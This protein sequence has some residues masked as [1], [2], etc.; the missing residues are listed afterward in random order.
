MKPNSHLSPEINGNLEASGP[1]NGLWVTRPVGEIVKDEPFLAVG[2]VL[3]ITTQNT[4]YTLEKTGDAEFLISGNY[5]LC[6]QPTKCEIQGS[7]WGGSIMKMGWIGLGMCLVYVIDGKAVRTS[8]V[9]VI[10][11]R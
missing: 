11:E 3:T 10:V 9:Q 5:R 8:L 4:D 6:P 2:R 7:T 1:S